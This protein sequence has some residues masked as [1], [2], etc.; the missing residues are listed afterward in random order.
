MCVNINITKENVLVLLEAYTEAVNIS[1]A[2]GQL[3]IHFAAK[4]L[5]AD[6]LRI[7]TEA[8]PDNLTAT[9]STSESVAHCA[10]ISGQLKNITYIHSLMPELF[11]TINDRQMTPMRFAV[12][13]FSWQSCIAERVSPFQIID[14][15]SLVPETARSLIATF[16]IQSWNSQH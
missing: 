10:A 16:C 4:N 14:L 1:D 2:D 7:I 11:R 15:L 8:N 9:N 6:I 3:P 5:N 13:E 12:E